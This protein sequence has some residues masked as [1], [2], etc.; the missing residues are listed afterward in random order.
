MLLREQEAAY[1][2]E[3]LRGAKLTIASR[4]RSVKIRSRL[5]QSTTPKPI[6]LGQ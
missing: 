6:N 2:D 3:R 1:R 5:N 4:A